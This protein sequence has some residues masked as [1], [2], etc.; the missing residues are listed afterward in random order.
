[1]FHPK[2]EDVEFIPSVEHILSKVE[3]F[4][5]KKQNNI[6][7]C[8]VFIYRT[9]WKQFCLKEHKESKNLEQKFPKNQKHIKFSDVQK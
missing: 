2:I 8:D 7:I 1:M 5:P 3:K 4:L 9:N 6:N